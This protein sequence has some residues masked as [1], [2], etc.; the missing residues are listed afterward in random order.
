MAS[1]RRGVGVV[2]RGDNVSECFVSPF[3]LGFGRLVFSC[4]PLFSTKVN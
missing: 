1:A 4:L 2:R 3:L